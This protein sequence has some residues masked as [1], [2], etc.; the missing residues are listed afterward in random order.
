[1]VIP[2]VREFYVQFATQFAHALSHAGD[3]DTGFRRL[4][5]SCTKSLSVVLNGKQD[6]P[7]LQA[8]ANRG[9]LTARVAVDVREAFLQD[10]K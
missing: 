3:A 2:V 10:S 4:S 6:V 1:M 9:R 7:V 5:I 8:E